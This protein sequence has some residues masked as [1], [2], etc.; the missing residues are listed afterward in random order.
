MSGSNNSAPDNTGAARQVNGT[1]V[2]LSA[3]Y[4]DSKNKTHKTGDV[5][6]FANDQDSRAELD[7]L[8]RFGLAVLDGGK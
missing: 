8:V 2:K 1:S 6:T 3:P 4:T 7:R 5:I